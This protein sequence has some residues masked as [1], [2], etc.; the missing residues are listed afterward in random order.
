MSDRTCSIE[1][2]EAAHQARGWCAMHYKRYLKTGDPLK[3]VQPARPIYPD[4]ACTLCGKMF[5][6][7]VYNQKRCSSKCTRRAAHLRAGARQRGGPVPGS[8]SCAICGTEFPMISTRQRYCGRRCRMRAK[9]QY[10]RYRVAAKRKAVYER[11]EN[12]CQLCLL[13]VDTSIPYPHPL[14]ATLDHIVPVTAG[15]THDIGNL[16]LAHMACNAS[17]GGASRVYAVPT[18]EMPDVWT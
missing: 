6:P 17:K 5:S 2:C 1:G 8:A 14:A 16:Q 15:G 9:D 3:T 18:S 4:R 13:P 10:R 11:D 7:A 12:I